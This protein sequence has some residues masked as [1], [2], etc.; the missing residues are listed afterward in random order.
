MRRQEKPIVIDPE[1]WRWTPESVATDERI[2]LSVL[3]VVD[4]E[5]VQSIVAYHFPERAAE[6]DVAQ[7][8]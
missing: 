4:E 8:D 6:R 7:E 5:Y 3:G 2:R 1:K